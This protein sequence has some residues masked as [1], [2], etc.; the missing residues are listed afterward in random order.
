MFAVYLSF[1]EVRLELSFASDISVSTQ[2]FSV[3][4]D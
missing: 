1:L 2:K 3:V 4:T